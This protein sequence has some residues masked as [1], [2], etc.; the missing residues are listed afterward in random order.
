MAEYDI[1]PGNRRHRTLGYT[2]KDGSAGVVQ[3]PPEWIRSDEALAQVDVDPDG[4]HGTIAHNG[5]VGDLT[6]DS[7]AD[8]DIGL[9]EHLIVI[10]DTFHML[11]P[12]DAEGGTS[13]VGEEEPI[14]A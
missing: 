14:P 2:K 9:G 10:S 1:R 3:D 4:M 12:R 5:A 6:I 11:P 13:E 8:G 7:R